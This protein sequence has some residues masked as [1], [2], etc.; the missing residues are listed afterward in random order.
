M[1]GDFAINID[2]IKRQIAKAEVFSLYFPFLSQTLLVDTRL[3]AEHGPFIRV[4]PMVSSIEERLWSL[5]KMRPY[6]PRPRSMVA[7]P[8]PRYV[9]ALERVGIWQEVVRRLCATGFAGIEHECQEV[10]ARLL[11]LEQE[12]MMNAITGAGYRTLWKTPT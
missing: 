2:E 8:W 10:F 1:N 9:A 5:K 3:T 12:E 4:L 6:L 11:Q 7:I